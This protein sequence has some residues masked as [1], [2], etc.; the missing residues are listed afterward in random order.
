MFKAD[1][2]VVIANITCKVLTNLDEGTQTRNWMPSTTT[3]T[4][5]TTSTTTP[6]LL[7]LLHYYYYYYYYCT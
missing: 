2:S 1:I 4:T 5:I 6:L 7:L 3:T